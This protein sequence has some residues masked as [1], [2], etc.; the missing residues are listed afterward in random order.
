MRQ[1]KQELYERIMKKVAPIVKQAINEKFN[2]V[3]ALPARSSINESLL[4]INTE[5]VSDP[6]MYLYNQITPSDDTLNTVN[7]FFTQLCTLFQSL[8]N[9]LE[10]YKQNNGY[11]GDITNISGIQCE[12]NLYI[13]DE[14]WL[15]N[16]SVD[17]YR[18][19]DFDIE[20]DYNADLTRDLVPSRFSENTLN[21]FAKYLETLKYLEVVGLYNKF[22]GRMV[23]PAI[24]FI[25]FDNVNIKALENNFKSYQSYENQ[26]MNVLN[27]LEK[28]PFK[29]IS[30]EGDID[31]FFFIQIK[32]V[33]NL[34]GLFNE[35]IK[36][37]EYVIKSFKAWAK[38]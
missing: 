17:E 1:S 29:Y 14:G 11:N 5:M 31:T 2:S 25:S 21:I 10:T 27:T 16:D 36:V 24:A 34:S 38:I 32:S 19:D 22:M 23:G 8:K 30:F 15:Y 37:Y 4:N 18:L 13:R 6:F 33:Q 9:D 3:K 35:I 26:M 12:L 7:Q 20:K 28:K